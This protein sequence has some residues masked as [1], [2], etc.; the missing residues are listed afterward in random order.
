MYCWLI[1]IRLGYLIFQKGN[2]CTIEP[3]MPSRFAHQISYDQLYVSKPS[4]LHFSDNMYGRGT[5]MVLLCVWRTCVRS[6]LPQK[7]LNSYASL[8][9]C[10]W[11]ITAD[12]VP[13][14]N[15]NCSDIKQIKTMYQARKSSK[16]TCLKGMNK[17]L[18][19][20]IEAD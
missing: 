12:L 3:W 7:M 5:G 1:N 4:D 18:E 20:D 2:V 15:M 6:N 16:N 10:V 11:Y 8:G 19:A 13:L 14:Y 17:F 9:F